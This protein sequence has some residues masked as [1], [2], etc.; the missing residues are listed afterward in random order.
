MAERTLYETLMLH[1][2]ATAEVITAVYRV[3]AKQ[4]HPDRAGPGAEGRM[5]AINE[6]HA[7]LSNP[8]KRARYD[9]S[10]GL[11]QGK[12]GH[13]TT[14]AR[15]SAP[16]AVN[17]KYESGTWAIRDP[18]EPTPPP[19]PY[20]EVGPPPSYPPAVGSILSFGRYRGWTISQVAAHDRNYVEWLSRTMAGR[21]YRTELERFLV[22]TPA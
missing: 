19:S 17:L 13:A 20:G 11:K 1:P 4:Y 16:G 6:A 3:L 15:P 2:S 9:A 22:R 5:A 21:T 14:H 10:I 12:E 7:I 8:D 18:L